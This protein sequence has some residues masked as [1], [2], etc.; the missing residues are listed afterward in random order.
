[1]SKSPTIDG[2]QMTAALLAPRIATSIGRRY[3]WF[4][5]LGRGG[6]LECDGKRLTL[7]DRSDRVIVTAD[8]GEIGVR[9][10]RLDVF[11][12]RV[13]ANSYDLFGVDPSTVRRRGRRRKLLAYLDRHDTLDHVPG[14]CDEDDRNPEYHGARKVI[15]SELWVALLG[16]R[17]AT[18]L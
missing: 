16:T 2:E 7:Y 5:P 13:G 10:L 11:R 9:K 6:C 12:V 1:M 8:V 18:P 4:P 17:G 3:R 15:W 14:L